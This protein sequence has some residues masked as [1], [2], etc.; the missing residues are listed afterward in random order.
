MNCWFCGG[1]MCW[2]ADFGADEVGTGDENQVAAEL[3]CMNCGATATFTSPP[4]NEDI[5]S[6]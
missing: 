1:E 3:H 2:D 4:P 5:N 6:D